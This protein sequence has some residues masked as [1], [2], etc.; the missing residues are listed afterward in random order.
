MKKALRITAFVLAVLV[1]L[2]A[3]W[4][5]I[6][7][8]IIG[9]NATVLSTKN[10]KISGAMMSYLV[11]KQ[12]EEYIDDNTAVFGKDYMETVGLNE[13]KS[14]K[15]QKSTYGES[16]FSYFYDKALEAM[17]ETLLLCEAANGANITLTDKEVKALETAAAEYEKYGKDNVLYVMKAKALAK[18]YEENF[19]SS[20]D[21]DAA[22]YEKYYEDNKEEFD[23]VDYKYMEFAAIQDETFDKEAAYIAAKSAANK[24]VSQLKTQ[25]F[26]ALAQDYLA[27][28]ESEKTIADYTVTEYQY[29]VRTNFGNWAFAE[30][31]KAGDVIIF[32]GTGQFAVYYIVKAPYKHDYTTKKVQML[33]M[34]LGQDPYDTVEKMQEIYYKWQEMED[35]SE[36]TFKTLSDDIELTNVYKEYSSDKLIEWVYSDKR[37]EGDWD[38]VEDQSNLYLIR[39]IGDGE[40]SFYLK[41]NEYLGES[42]FDKMLKGTEEKYSVKINKG[43]KNFVK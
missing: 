1:C 40:S 12:M 6:I 4:F 21:Y 38:V 36:E 14:L 8:P 27:S 28:I 19:Y 13:D 22:E 25:D 16:W 11:K 35:K 37:V 39:Y 18:K 23:V 2:S 17:K 3:V 7:S 42:D 15:W 31:R 9:K 10:Y 5:L 30:E 43:V 41:A 33:T 26:D 29:E 32:E 20:L 24:F 34:S